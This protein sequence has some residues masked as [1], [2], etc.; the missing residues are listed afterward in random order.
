MPPRYPVESEPFMVES[1]VPVGES[2]V[3]THVVVPFFQAII[4]M[5]LIA[6]CV[7]LWQWHAIAGVV[8]A[9]GL[10][11]WGWRVLLGDRLLWKLETITG[12]ELDGTPG[13]G[14]PQPFGMINP[15]AARRTADGFAAASDTRSRQAEL[16]AF[17]ARC[18]TL[19]ES[20]Q[21]QGISAGQRELYCD[22]RDTLINLGLAAWKVPGNA[23]LGWKLRVTPEQA[24]TIIAQHIR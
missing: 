6:G 8:G 13:L 15:E 19:G 5:A 2:R 3:T 24:Q 23:R 20:E 17:V 7:L 11:V 10:I 21:A 14:K 16:L 4:T 22:Q 12:R 18:A 9:V 1:R